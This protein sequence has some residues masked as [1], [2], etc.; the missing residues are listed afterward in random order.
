MD[1]FL[2]KKIT[3][4]LLLLYYMCVCVLSVCVCVS[5]CVCLRVCVCVCVSLKDALVTLFALIT[6]SYSR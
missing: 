1:I 6:L 3:N 2:L 4:K 5:V